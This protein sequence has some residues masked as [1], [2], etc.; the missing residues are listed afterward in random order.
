M[1]QKFVLEFRFYSL[2]SV[3]CKRKKCGAKVCVGVQ[4]PF[5]GKCFVQ[6]GKSIVQKSV[7]EFGTHSLRSVLCKSVKKGDSKGSSVA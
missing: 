6:K 1:V 2:G 5:S 4:I 3:L 7:L